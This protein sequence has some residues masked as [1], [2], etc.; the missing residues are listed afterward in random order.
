MHRGF[1][2]GKWTGA[3]T[4][5]AVIIKCAAVSCEIATDEGAVFEDSLTALQRASVRL[6]SALIGFMGL[7]G[8]TREL[9]FVCFV[10]NTRFIHLRE[11]RYTIGLEK[12][13]RA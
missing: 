10:G 2:K 5:I 9:I 7:Q 3:V 1:L 11:R 8:G 4:I 6:A 13:A 12:I